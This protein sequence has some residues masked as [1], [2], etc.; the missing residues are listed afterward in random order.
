MRVEEYN[1]LTY[2]LSYCS[3]GMIW[4]SKSTRENKER[5]SRIKQDNRASSLEHAAHLHF[6]KG[7]S[8]VY[9]TSNIP[10]SA[11]AEIS[12]SYLHFPDTRET[13]VAVHMF[14]VNRHGLI[15]LISITVT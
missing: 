6:I 13:C 8:I 11:F 9:I 5:C 2:L 3:F 14:F 15:D 10:V 7:S 12:S 4:L 1:N